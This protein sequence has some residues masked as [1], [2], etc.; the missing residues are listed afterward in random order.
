MENVVQPVTRVSLSQ[1]SATLGSGETLTLAA[2]VSPD[3]AYDKSL[4]WTSSDE[5]VAT[6][7]QNGVVT[8]IKSGTAKITAKALDGS[9]KSATCSI[10]VTGNSQVVTSV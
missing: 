4:E 6:V 9:E 2:T 8:A 7:D 10:T 3:N 1:T 5:S